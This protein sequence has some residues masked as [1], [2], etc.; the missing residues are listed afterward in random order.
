MRKKINRKIPARRPQ[1]SVAGMPPLIFAAKTKSEEARITRLKKD[2]KIRKVGPRL[3]TSVPG[4]DIAA[5]VRGHWSN[6]VSQL[7]PEA[8]LSHRSA[9]EY[10]PS[11]TGDI[12]LS[13]TTNRIVEYPGLTLHFVRGPK[14]QDSDLPFLGFHASSQGRAFL[15]NLS[16]TKTTAWRALSVPELESRL[17]DI[18]AAKGDDELRRILQQ[19]REIAQ[20]FAWE[21]ELEK[22]EIMIG[23]ML[24]DAASHKLESSV[25]R[26]RAKGQPYDSARVARLDVLYSALRATP[27]KEF[28]DSARAGDHFRN[29]AFFEAYFS[30]YIEGTTFEV[31]E[32]EEIIFDK[33]IPEERPKDAHDI[34]A[35]FNIVSDAN[36][37]RKVPKEQEELVA[38]IKG[39]HKILMADRPEASP[40]QFKERSNRVGESHF[41]R[42]SEVVGT[43]NK[44]FERYQELPAGL[45]RAVFVMFLVA[46][47]H[48]FVDGNG[49]IARIM[50]N[51]EL[52]A[53][54]LATI[55]IPTVYR[56]DY[57][58]ALRALT[59]RDRPEPLIK[60]LARAHSFSNL[61]YSPYKK[62]L[63]EL[64]RR[65]WFREPDSGKI[66]EG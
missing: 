54:G 52:C 13:S 11:P 58:S 66:I 65:N 51:S 31:E 17:N 47:V 2:K 43:M 36:E 53:E 32:A 62:I 12:I 41:V 1:N 6:I 27:L 46:E 25:G 34:V 18:S 57:L 16:T 28:R 22:L 55:I 38:M 3:Y 15:E 5:V 42:P 30:N 24:G 50:M 37:M 61:A 4:P 45:A 10:K 44:G 40:G 59:R 48:P 63:D 20:E 39:R 14:V 35:T 49:R 29:K 23:A 26:A 8:L 33:K 9:L 60:M 56:E 64:T 21:R 7:Y 19:A